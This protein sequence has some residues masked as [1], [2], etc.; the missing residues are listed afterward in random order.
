[1]NGAGEV[2]ILHSVLFP[3]NDWTDRKAILWLSNY[4]LDYI[5]KRQSDKFYYYRINEVVPDMDF[6]T[7]M[8]PNKIHLVY[9]Y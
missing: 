5:H 2:K 8:L 7:V 4:Q 6:M 1:M 9:Q 3:K